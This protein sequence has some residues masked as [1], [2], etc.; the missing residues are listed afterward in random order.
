[1][2]VGDGSLALV[3]GKGRVGREIW[4]NNNNNNNGDDNESMEK[5]FDDWQP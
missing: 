3:S 5:V 4:N 1:M 2:G